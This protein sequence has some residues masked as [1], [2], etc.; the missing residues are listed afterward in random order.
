MTQ[1]YEEQVYEAEVKEN[2]Q[3]VTEKVAQ[4]VKEREMD[5]LVGDQT[6]KYH[7]RVMTPKQAQRKLWAKYFRPSV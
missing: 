6:P 4:K 7:E 1:T 5:A 3:K 2:E